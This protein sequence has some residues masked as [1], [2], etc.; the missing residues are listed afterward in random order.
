VQ[1]TELKFDLVSPV[2]E[3]AKQLRME[4]DFKHE[5]RVMDEIRQTLQV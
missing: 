4:F 1:K 3:L 5:A 2:D